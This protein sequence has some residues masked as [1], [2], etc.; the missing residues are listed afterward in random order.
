MES[1]PGFSG[2]LGADG[3]VQRSKATTPPRLPV[4]PR[5]NLHLYDHE[6]NRAIAVTSLPWSFEASVRSGLNMDSNEAQP[7]D[8]L[9]A[10]QF[11]LLRHPRSAMCAQPTG[12]REVTVIVRWI[13][14]V[15]AA[16]GMRVARPAR[17]TG[18]QLAA[19]APSS[20]GGRGPS[21]VT[22]RL[23]GKGPEGSRQ[24]TRETRTL[25]RLLS[26]GLIAASLAI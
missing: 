24:P 25:A 22:H 5:R 16:Y 23:A 3:A 7:P 14:L 8:P 18:S 12:L 9:H 26:R 21:S 17:T 15:T 2:L 19:T 20:T 11:R 13:P 10:L 6:G 4:R 1:S